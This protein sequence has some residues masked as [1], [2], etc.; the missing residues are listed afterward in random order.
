M[1]F[2]SLQ[3]DITKIERFEDYF[4]VYG[5]DGTEF[6]WELKGKRI[7]YENNRLETPSLEEYIDNTAVFTEDDLEPITS[8]EILTQELE[9]KLEDLLLEEEV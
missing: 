8:K 2:R 3:G 9:F 7:G 6:S 5:E 4:I 1:L